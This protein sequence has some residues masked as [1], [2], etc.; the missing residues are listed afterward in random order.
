MFAFKQSALE[1]TTFFNVVMRQELEVKHPNTR[2]RNRYFWRMII[3]APPSSEDSRPSTLDDID[4][5][6]IARLDALLAGFTVAEC[7]GDDIIYTTYHQ[8]LVLA[9][10]A[11]TPVL[12][13]DQASHITLSRQLCV[14]SLPPLFVREIEL[15]KP[16]ALAIMAYIIALDTL[17]QLG[18]LWLIEGEAGYAVKK[19][20][21]LKALI[22]PEWRSGT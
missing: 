22:A 13:D 11:W 4:L 5:P 8:A 17:P 16:R 3:N 15:R 10:A 12:R 19:L 20:A 14:C 7:N 1:E 9:K 21:T 6:P 2:F 18:S